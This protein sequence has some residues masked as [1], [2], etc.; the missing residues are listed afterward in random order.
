MDQERQD[1]EDLE[2]MEGYEGFEEEQ[3]ENDFDDRNFD[4][5]D[6]NV[7][8]QKRLHLDINPTNASTLHSEEGDRIY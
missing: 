2:N 7:T 3:F 6:V 5:Y 1:E 4:A 8:S